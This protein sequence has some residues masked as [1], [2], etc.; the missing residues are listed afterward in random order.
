[1]TCAK[2]PA[3]LGPQLTGWPRLWKPTGWLLA[4]PKA[5]GQSAR[6]SLEIETTCSPAPSRSWISSWKKPANLSSYINGQKPPARA[7]PPQSPA[8]DSTMSYPSAA[9][10]RSPLVQPR[11]LSPLL[12]M[13]PSMTL[14]SPK[15]ML[16]LLKKQDTPNPSKNV[17]RAWPQYLLPSWIPMVNSSRCFPSPVL[18]T[19]LNLL[20]PRNSASNSWQLPAHYALAFKPCTHQ[21]IVARRSIHLCLS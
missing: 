5:N 2:P 13:S 1:M 9:N 4:L 17:K 16:M 12:L 15:L 7:W 19:V 14:P 10:C 3:Y 8:K 11:G 20:P 6:P 21:A 18:L